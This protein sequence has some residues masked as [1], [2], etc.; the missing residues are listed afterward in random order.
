MYKSR[1]LYV[2]LKSHLRYIPQPNRT[3]SCVC[4]SG[5]KYLINIRQRLINRA[6]LLL[7]EIKSEKRF[8]VF[9]S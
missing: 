3:Q 6:L 7:F 5:C 2:Q 1:I 8:C 9:N 4:D